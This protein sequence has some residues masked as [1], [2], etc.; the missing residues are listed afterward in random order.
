MVLN[1]LEGLLSAKG[2][3]F[4]LEVTATRRFSNALKGAIGQHRDIVFYFLREA[5]PDITGFIRSEYSID[6]FVCEIKNEV[7][8][9]DDI[10]QARKY[11]ELFDAKYCLLI[12]PYEVP[13]ELKRLQR[14]V[15]PLL[16][17]PS[18]K[19]LAFARFDEDLRDLVDWFPRNPLDEI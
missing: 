15:V 10:Y 17:L 6:F 14:V 5:A 18:Y 12:S 7:F 1:K 13:D 11:A 2:A 4:H 16:A 9:L 8:K 19:N 3:D